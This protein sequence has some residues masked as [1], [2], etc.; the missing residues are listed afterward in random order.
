MGLFAEIV[1]GERIHFRERG[2]INSNFALSTHT[3]LN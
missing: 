1:R 3:D 2:E